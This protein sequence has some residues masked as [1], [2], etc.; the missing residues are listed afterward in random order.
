MWVIIISVVLIVIFRAMFPRSEKQQAEWDSLTENEQ[1][2][3]FVKGY[4][5]GGIVIILCIPVL[6]ILT[7][8]FDWHK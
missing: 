2:M 4:V 5:G 8:L 3:E 7:D 6:I 1:L